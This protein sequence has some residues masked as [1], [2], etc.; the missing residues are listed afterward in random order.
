MKWDRDRG[1]VSDGYHMLYELYEHRAELYLTLCVAAKLAAEKVWRSRLHSDGSSLPGWF[2]LGIWMAKGSQITYHM[3]DA[4]WD[5]C[6][7]AETL[8][9]APEFDGHTPDDVLQ[10]LGAMRRTWLA[11]RSWAGV[12]K[13]DDRVL[14]TLMLVEKMSWDLLAAST[15]KTAMEAALLRTQQENERLRAVAD[16][17]SRRLKL[18]RKKNRTT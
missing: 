1:K 15:A 16:D 3:P 6:E 12:Q 7:F 5:R 2:V 17:F 18:C 10:R 4:D 14:G 13:P 11:R 9:R 8:E